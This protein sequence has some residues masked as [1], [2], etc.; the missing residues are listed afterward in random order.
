MIKVEGYIAFRGVM[1]ITPTGYNLL[2]FEVDGS[3]LYKPECDCWYCNGRS[4][5]ADIC[6]I[7]SDKGVL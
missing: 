3:W 4:Y 1:R 2:P 7:V 6:E 5:P